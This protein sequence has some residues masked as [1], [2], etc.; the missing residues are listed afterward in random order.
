[1]RA[2]GAIK[3]RTKQVTG[4]TWTWK[5]NQHVA[6]RVSVTCL[7]ARARIAFAYEIPNG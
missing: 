2:R 5:P 4:W 7:K 1:M 6:Q 3:H